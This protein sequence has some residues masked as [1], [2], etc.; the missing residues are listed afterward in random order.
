MENEMPAK[1]ATTCL[2]KLT[3]IK[4]CSKMQ[5]LA[6]RLT[7]NSCHQTVLKRR[8][9]INRSHGF[10]NALAEAKAALSDKAK[11]AAAAMAASLPTGFD[12]FRRDAAGG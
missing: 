1:D 12:G 11:G 3:V 2:L 9:D 7:D 4:M 6:D 5:L 10:K 8:R